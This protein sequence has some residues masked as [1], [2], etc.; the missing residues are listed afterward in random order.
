METSVILL[1]SNGNR[2]HD[3]A[4]FPDHLFTDAF[5]G[6][7]DRIMRRKMEKA[8][9]WF[10]SVI[11][12]ALAVILVIVLL[13][14]AGDLIKRFLPDIT[15]EIRTQSAILEQKMEAS[16][17]LEVTKIDETGVLEAETSVI[18]FG[19]V[20]RTTIRYRYTAS[21]GIDLSKVS[22]MTE[23]DR[24]LFILP[25]PEVLNDGI[26]AL[27]INRKNLFS[28]AIDKSVETLLAEQKQKCR[29][30]YLSETQH[31]EKTWEDTVRAFNETICKWLDAY[32]ER[33]YQ[34]EFTR[35]QESEAVPSASF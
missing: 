7:A 22:M 14:F 35:K 1:D 28:K 15:G 12:K 23:N 17:R 5:A 30:Q 6:N 26:E 2:I 4:L 8:G 25:E 10:L 18:V 31:S 27:E 34:F 3:C 9:K 29:E 16:Q 32:G 11:S 13:P 21:I 20:G 33:H 24:I 19:T